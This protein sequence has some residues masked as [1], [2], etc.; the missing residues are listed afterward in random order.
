[1]SEIRKL[2]QEKEETRNEVMMQYN[3]ILLETTAEVK[4]INEQIQWLSVSLKTRF[5]V[6]EFEGGRRADINSVNKLFERCHSLK[7]RTYVHTSM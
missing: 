5:T 2:E 4:Q 1:M 3:D 7:V 6:L